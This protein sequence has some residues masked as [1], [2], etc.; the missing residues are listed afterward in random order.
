MK[1]HISFKHA[2]DGIV[3]VIKTQPNFRIHISAA[4]A[5]LISAFFLKIKYTDL[6]ILLFT[7]SL[8][9]TAEM[10][11]TSIE[12]ITDLVTQKVHPLAKIAKDVSAGMVLVSA[13]LSIVVGFAVYWPYIQTILKTQ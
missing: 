8:V 5:V 1:H 13:V 7:I 4:I 11:N 10:I 12:A 3:Y 6:I 9:I 2:L